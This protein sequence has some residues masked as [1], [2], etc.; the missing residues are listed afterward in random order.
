MNSLGI[1]DEFM[2]PK[3]KKIWLYCI[4]YKQRLLMAFFMSL[5][6]ILIRVYM[7]LNSIC[8]FQCI[9]HLLSVV[10]VIQTTFHGPSSCILGTQAI[11]KLYSLWI[12]WVLRMSS[13]G[14]KEKK[15]WLYCIFYKQ[16]L[17]MAFFM[18]LKHIL[19]RVYMNLNII[20]FQII[21]CKRF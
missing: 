16:R 11:H 14:P 3:R 2:W 15:I 17:L 9:W 6:H 8:F 10:Y 18:S 20:C 12:A 5:K 21:R 19:I 1:E 7:T 4:F 13:C